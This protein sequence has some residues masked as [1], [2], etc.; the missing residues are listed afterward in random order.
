MKCKLGR[1]P[2][3]LSKALLR[4]GFFPRND[5]NK[6]ALHDLRRGISKAKFWEMGLPSSRCRGT[7]TQAIRPHD[8]DPWGLLTPGVPAEEC[9]FYSLARCINSSCAA[10]RHTVDRASDR[11]F[12][13]SSRELEGQRQSK[14]SPS[15]TCREIS[16]PPHFDICILQSRKDWRKW[17]IS[18]V[19]ERIYMLFPYLCSSLSIC[20]KS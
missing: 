2:S 10:S 19:F 12:H 7:T 8:C 1:L 5:D 16:R 13:K 17:G 9:V 3:R 11:R 4:D 15:V 14:T 6:A 20:E 18:D